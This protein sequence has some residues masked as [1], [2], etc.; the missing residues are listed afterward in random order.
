MLALEWKQAPEK[1]C[2]SWLFTVG[3]RN[4]WLTRQQYYQDYAHVTTDPYNF[5]LQTGKQK[6]GIAHGFE[7]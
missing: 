3:C 5:F 1:L 2:A 6:A 4:P 7:K